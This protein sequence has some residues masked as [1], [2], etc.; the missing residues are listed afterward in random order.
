MRW[1]VTLC[2]VY[3]GV[4]AIYAQEQDHSLID[5]LLRPNL[6]LQNS[7]QGKKF[8]TNSA[9]IEHRGTVDTFFLER[10][11]KQ[12][13]FADTRVLS[14][15]EYR[16]RSFNGRSSASAVSEIRSVHLSAAVETSSFRGGTGAYDAN[17]TVLGR[18]FADQHPFREE[19]KS[20]KSLD[21]QNPTLTIEQVRELLNK[22]K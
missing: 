2:L 19:G 12:K 10:N 18:N 5:R 6:E 4:P 7:A 22:N 14:T 16:A 20:Q 8:A 17:T 11:W 1:L 21:R 15:K 9:V 3:L 13:S